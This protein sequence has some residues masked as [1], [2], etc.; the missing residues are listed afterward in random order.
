MFTT[1]MLFALSVIAISL[2]A[3]CSV[4]G[5]WVYAGLEPE[6]ARED[7]NLLGTSVYGNELTG[8]DIR[9]DED[10]TYTADIKYGEMAKIRSGTWKTDSDLITFIDNT[11]ESYTYHYRLKDNKLHLKKLIEGTEVVLTLER[12]P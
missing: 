3:G 6:M 9:L 7:I 4:Q 5:D 1:K 11:G 8:A 10:K 12:K 2:F